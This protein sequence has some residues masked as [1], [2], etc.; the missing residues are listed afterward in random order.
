MVS[1]KNESNTSVSKD[2]DESSAELNTVSTQGLLRDIMH[3]DPILVH[4]GLLLLQESQAEIRDTE[5]V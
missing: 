2:D 1:G 5:A 4:F 3:F